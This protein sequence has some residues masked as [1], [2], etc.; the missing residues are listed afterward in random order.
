ML[1]FFSTSKK[2]YN[3][4]SVFEKWHFET[5]H[6]VFS[7]VSSTYDLM[8]DVM[9][10]GCHHVWKYAF[11]QHIN[12]SALPRSFAYVDM[13]CGSGDVGHMVLQRNHMM[14]KKNI[15]PFFVDPNPNMLQE[16]KIKHKDYPI[17]WR[18]ENAEQCTLNSQSIGLYTMAFGLRNVSNRT[19]CLHNAV[20]MLAP[21]GQFWCLEFSWPHHPVLAA[22][23]D[24][25]LG[26]LPAIGQ[27]IAHNAN[28][29]AYLA[30]S[31][32][33]FPSPSVIEQEMQGA[34]LKNTGVHSISNGIVSIFRG[35]KV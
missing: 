6:Q 16:G 13:A 19:E 20:R 21:G 18:Q 31:I 28:A 29:Y 2:L 14:H 24:G 15:T 23:Y 4:K 35:Y 34:G 27:I 25:Y 11:V 26:L 9:S 12:W 1:L 5:I 32:R 33:A 10:L 3:V 30:D 17:Q 7:A 8:N 22:L